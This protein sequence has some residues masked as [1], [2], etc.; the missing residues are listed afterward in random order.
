VFL[1]GDIVDR[2]DRHSAAFVNR[3]IGELR[4]LAGR[5]YT[6]ILR[7][8]HDTT[9]HPPAFWEFLT[10]FKNLRYVIKPEPYLDDLL[11]LPF[12]AKPMQDWGNI[13]LSDYR[14]LFMHATITGAVAEN[15]Q[16]M[17]NNHF[18]ILPRKARIYSGDVHVPQQVRNITYVGAPHPIKFGDNYPCRMLLLN[19]DYDI[20]RELSVP[21]MRKVMADIS[22][23]RELASLRVTHGDQVKIRFNCS[24]AQIEGWGAIERTINE[25]AVNNGIVI[26]GV[27][28]IVNSARSMRGTDIIEQ[29]PEQIMHQFAAHEHLDELLEVG[30]TLLNEAR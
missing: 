8:N 17:E 9:M 19:N 14:A 2:K 3:L 5:A 30:L 24:T 13:R 11:V 26:A 4:K 10:Q 21:T 25:W 28:A 12:T 22:H 1:L 7:G 23:V 6:V 16:V 20:E 18:P 15:G 27:E 29:S